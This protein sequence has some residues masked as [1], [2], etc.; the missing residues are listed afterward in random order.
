MG[1]ET[2][3]M[4]LSLKAHFKKIGYETQRVDLS[5]TEHFKNGIWNSKDGFESQRTFLNIRYETQGGIM[6]LTGH[7]KKWDMKLKCR[8]WVSKHILKN[9]IWNSKRGFESQRTH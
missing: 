1:Y 2:Q 5:L 8:I 4:D 6:S 9:G 7:F 3:R